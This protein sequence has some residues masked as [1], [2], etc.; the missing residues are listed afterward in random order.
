M[1]KLK[2]GLI[3]TSNYIVKDGFRKPLSDHDDIDLRIISL[4]GSSSSVAAWALA[5]PTFKGLDIVMFDIWNNEELFLNMKRSTKANVINNALTLIDAISRSGAVPVAV[6]FPRLRASAARH[7]TAH[8]FCMPLCRDLGIAYLDIYDVLETIL[9]RSSDKTSRTD[10]FRDGA[11]IQKSIARALAERI[12]PA[13]FDL[14]STT[15]REHAVDGF[16][17]TR[18]VDASALF[19]DV[20]L[21]TRKSALL[22]MDFANIV[23]PTH[24]SL[25][26]GGGLI[27]VLLN[28]AVSTSALYL[29]G[30]K[31]IDYLPKDESTGRTVP[32][33]FIAT[34]A[35]ADCPVPEAP[36]IFS[37][38]GSKVDEAEA[39]VELGG[40]VLASA[41]RST[42]V[43][44][45]SA[46]PET[47]DLAR[48]LD[49]A[50]YDR[51]IADPPGD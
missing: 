50:F 27:A 33:E 4:G 12:I 18:F 15:L 3:G 9:D 32:T 38:A 13:L 47:R 19:P 35:P 46:D 29:N 36:H 14:T 43:Q 8:S 21:I 16:S 37:P 6:A 39:C 10:L 42:S 24:C 26:S 44:V 41:E 22:S 2:V 25:G 51:M 11:H 7:K 30:N 23:G 17:K 28:H 45:R 48:S 31:V 49:D 5:Q 20:P 1:P 40:V 34:L